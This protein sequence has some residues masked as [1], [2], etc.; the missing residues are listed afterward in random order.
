MAT[1]MNVKEF[2]NISPTVPNFVFFFIQS[3]KLHTYD[4]GL[5]KTLKWFPLKNYTHL[6][7]TILKAP[8]P[9]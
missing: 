2:D 7:I 8:E 6:I 9:Y 5:S 4:S 3:A 1:P